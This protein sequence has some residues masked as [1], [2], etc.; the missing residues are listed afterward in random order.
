MGAVTWSG[1]VSPF[2][3][4]I[5]FAF[6]FFAFTFE[7]LQIVSNGVVCLVTICIFGG[8][9]LSLF[10]F[11]GLWVSVHEEINNYIPLCVTWEFSSK[12]EGL[13]GK[14]PEHVGNGV[15]GLVV[16]W[17]GNINPVEWRVRVAKSNDWDVHVGSLSE[18]LV[19]KAW[20]ADNHESWLQEPIIKYKLEL[21]EQSDLPPPIT[22]Y[23]LVFWLVSVPGTHFPPR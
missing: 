10:Y 4:I 15:A 5:F 9:F 17:N 18:T 8:I 21:I 13:T 11:L 7:L 3:G 20:I 12:L 6:F 22:T 23:F 1:V 19:V 2:F 14:E 16:G